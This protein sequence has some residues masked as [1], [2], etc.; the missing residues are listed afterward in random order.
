[1][2]EHNLAKPIPKNQVTKEARQHHR[3]RLILTALMVF[4]ELSAGHLV[5]AK[6]QLAGGNTL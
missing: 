2:A 4:R 6:A 3:Q 1:M 5:A